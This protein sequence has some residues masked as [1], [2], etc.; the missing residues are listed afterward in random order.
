M[1][2]LNSSA[3]RCKCGHDS[4]RID[5]KMRQA[6]YAELRQQEQPMP[7]WLH[8]V[9]SSYLSL[10]WICALILV[11]NEFMAPQRMW[12]MN[13]V[14]PINALY[15][16]PVAVWAYYRWGRLETKRAVMEARERGEENAGERKPFWAMVAIGTSHCGAGCTLGDI[17]AESLIYVL[18]LNFFG[19]IAHHDLFTAY[20]L[21]YMFAY[22]LG[23]VFQYFT[24]APMRHLGFLSGIWAAVKADTLSLTAFEVGLFGWM[25]L[26]AL[27]F[28]GQPLKKTDPVFWFMMQI[29]MMLG[30]LTSYPVNWWLLKTGLKEKM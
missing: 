5:L 28:F 2:V 3:G 15:W 30:F 18:G 20:V 10:C 7:S 24:I 1:L 27:V 19:S 17:M 12:I 22:V 21:D 11:M 13:V 25:A 26:P 29:G 16:G 4:F 6:V 23:I 9:A 14:W 8:L